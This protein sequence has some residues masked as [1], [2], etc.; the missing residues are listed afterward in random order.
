MWSF[1]V[2][3]RHFRVLI[4]LEAQTIQ[5]HTMGSSFTSLQGEGWR[6][7]GDEKEEKE[8]EGHE[9]GKGEK[10]N[11]KGFYRS[12]FKEAVQSKMV[13]QPPH[14]MPYFKFK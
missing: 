6:V 1:K 5:F 11:K 10:S 7:K 9:E 14:S 4:Q 2:L 3:A 13:V 8:E 12:G